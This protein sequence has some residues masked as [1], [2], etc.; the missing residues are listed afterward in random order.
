MLWRSRV[1]LLS[2]S[3]FYDRSNALQIGMYFSFLPCDR[4]LFISLFLTVSH[5][6]SRFTTSLFFSFSRFLFV[7]FFPSV[8]NPRSFIYFPL[9]LFSS[10]RPCAVR[11]SVKYHPCEMGCAAPFRK[12]RVLQYRITLPRARG[13]LDRRKIEDLRWK[14]IGESRAEKNDGA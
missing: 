14:E 1:A 13:P 7:A 8:H 6:P 4:S 5:S 9:R 10:N 11:M 12:A 2:F 3:A